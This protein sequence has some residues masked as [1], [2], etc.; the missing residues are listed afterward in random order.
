MKILIIGNSGSGKT[1]KGKEISKKYNIPLYEM[2]EI[3]WEP[4]GYNQK[5]P[6]EEI[7]KMVDNIKSRNSW[8]VEGVFGDI[9]SLFTKDATKLIWLDKNWNDCLS[10]L[11]KRGPSYNRYKNK[12]EAEQAFEELI[13]WASKYW[14]RD[15]SCSYNFHK[16]L[17]DMFQNNSSANQDIHLL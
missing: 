16:E 9:A 6:K 15:N 11:K 10:N 14:S 2:D 3:V 8:V 7:E 1:Y 12:N 17:F 5:R 4:C 13:N